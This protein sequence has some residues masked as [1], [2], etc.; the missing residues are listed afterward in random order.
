VKT[1]QD[2]VVI[3]GLKLAIVLWIDILLIVANQS[4]GPGLSV[5]LCPWVKDQR[6]KVKIRIRGK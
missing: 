6:V 1:P 5:Q 3:I 4:I 2:E